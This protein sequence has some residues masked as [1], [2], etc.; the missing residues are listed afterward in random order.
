M[1]KINFYFINCKYNIRD[2]KGIKEAIA[3]LIRKERRELTSLNCIFCS[4][5]YLLEMNKKYLKHNY[6]TDVLTFDMSNQ[7]EKIEGEIYIS[8]DRVLDNAR[9]MNVSQR[10]E[11]CR[12]VFHG[13]L[14]LCGYSDKKRADKKLIRKKENEYLAHYLPQFR[15]E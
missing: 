13:T 1:K 9:N 12:I 14:H 7:K 3:H 6:F 11:L 8:I 10:E 5:A 2:R 4:D 15:Q